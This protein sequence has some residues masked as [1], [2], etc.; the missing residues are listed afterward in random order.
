MRDGN[1]EGQVSLFRLLAVLV[2]VIIV[3]GPLMCF[4]APIATSCPKIL[5]F[6]GLDIRTENNE[7]EAR[8]WGQII[9]V[10]GFYVGN[11][12]ASWDDSVGND[13]ESKTYQEVKQFQETYSSFGVTDNFIK[14]ALYTK[15]HW[16]D[17]VAL[18]KVVENFREASHLARYAGMK[19][20][21]IDLEPYAAGYWDKDPAIPGKEEQVYLLG[22]RIGG[23]ILSEFPDATIIVL[24]EVLSYEDLSYSEGLRQAYALCSRFWDGLVQAHFKQLIISTETSYDSSRP[25]LVASNIKKVYQDNLSKNGVDPKS[26]AIAVGIWPLAKTYTDKSPRCTPSQFE[27]RLRLAFQLKSPYVWIYG[28]G[29]AWEKDGPYGKGDVAP[30][31]H[32][33]VR[34]VHKIEDSCA[35]SGNKPSMGEGDY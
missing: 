30:R 28:H 3:L 4:G 19:G 8:Y 18:S 14:V 25:D 12:M 35:T 20:L 22:R 27:E 2:G 23:A 32:E 6:D 33:Y 7:T 9:G 29:S 11:V 26:V 31:F 24:P 1:W 34:A 15:P 10:Q 21:A 16:G 5:M 13:E 17:Q